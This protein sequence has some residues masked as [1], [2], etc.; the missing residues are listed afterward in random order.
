VACRIYAP[1]GSHETL[2]AY[3]VRRILENGANA[4]F[5]NQVVDSSIPVATLLEDPVALAR[6]FEGSPHPIVPLPSAMFPDRR[7]SA[8]VDFS[9]DLALASL[10]ARIREAATASWKASPILASDG[11]ASSLEA[12]PVGSPADAAVVVGEVVEGDSQAVE[13][14]LRAAESASGWPAD[15][16][17]RRKMLLAAADLL[18]RHRGRLAW[19][20]AREAGKTLPN[21][22]GE[23]RE[24]VDYCRF[25]ASQLEG[26]DIGSPLGTVVCI[27][28]WNF[29]LAIFTGQVAAALAAGNRVIAKPAEQTP[30]IAAEAVRLFHEAGVPKAALQFLPGP[31]ETL[32]AALV[33][34]PRVNGIMFTG[35]VEVARAIHRT[36]AARG[37]VPLVAETGGQ[38]AMLVDSSALPEQVTADVIASAFD[39]A[40]QRCSALRVLLLQRE[41]ADRHIEMLAGAMRELV[42][43]DPLRLSTDVGP[44]IDAGAKA[45]L[46]AYIARLERAGKLISRAPQTGGE[47]GYFVAPVAFEID[48][49]DELEGEVFGPV[50][51]VL[52]YDAREL[53]RCVERLNALGYG[54]TFGMH[55]RLASRIERMSAQICVGNLYAN[56]NMIGAVVGVQPFGGEGLSGT[57]PKAGGPL[58]LRALVKREMVRD[59]GLRIPTL[60]SDRPVA[61]GVRK[62]RATRRG[63][64][65][66][67]AVLREHGNAA[68]A[69]MARWYSEAMKEL[70][71]R[72]LP[73]PTGERNR[74]FTVPRGALVA[75]GGEP[76]EA[77]DW[78]GQAMAAMA[79]G[80]QVVFVA[81]GDDPAARDVADWISRIGGPAIEVR[82]DPVQEWAA[83]PGLAAVLCADADRAAQAVARVSEREG[84]RI[85]VIEPESRR[86]AY[87]AWRLRAERSISENTT[88]SGGNAALLASVS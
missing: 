27:S 71:A 70:E 77:I 2:L 75:L 14:A 76:G 61:A 41:V 35:S 37:N 22:I 1:V 50:L 10:E 85:P 34:D 55:T 25:Y 7:N 58:T 62:Q 60:A 67:L 31:G 6:P 11:A 39:S 57:G 64:P 45:R 83:M 26:S 87:P 19:L 44:I 13:A 54:L 43:G 86:W 15:A 59:D 48:S 18:E 51:H 5:V 49:L 20:A 72:E 63:G 79:T 73:G 42:V 78:L 66:L 69:E 52:R 84:R 8:G 47:R 16:V 23:V 53:D 33:A 21:A 65:E 80:N 81:S 4:S 36:I 56:R 32:G 29:P 74:W 40:G 46:E 17:A 24:A 3:L 12:I 9:D 30:L 38:N 68:I 88:A 28:P 82:V